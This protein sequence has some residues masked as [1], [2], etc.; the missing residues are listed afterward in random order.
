MKVKTRDRIIN[1]SRQLFNQHG[2]RAITTNHIADHLGISPGNLYYHFK[3]KDE[4]IFEIFLQYEA[5]VAKN[6]V[7]IEDMTLDNIKRYFEL[8]FEVMTDY[9]FI[10]FNLPE[11]LGRNEALG[12]R[13]HVFAKR[14]L[15]NITKILQLFVKTGF[16]KETRSETLAA[17]AENIW[18]NTAYS[19][20]YQKTINEKGELPKE[21]SH[22]SMTLLFALLEPFVSDTSQQDYDGLKASFV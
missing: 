8:A 21:A 1:E 17:L 14:E 20:V 10:F 7:P 9:R 11:L 15:G 5:H 12:K 2:E 22:Q 16:F 4:I 13:Y 6:L 3:N 18:I 19:L